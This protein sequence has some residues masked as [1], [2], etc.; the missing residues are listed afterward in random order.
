MQFVKPTSADPKLLDVPLE[1][2]VWVRGI[3]KAKQV[4]TK[5]RGPAGAP[6][7]PAAPSAGEKT[8]EPPV[9]LEVDVK[10]W[11]LLNAARDDLPFKPNGHAD[12]LVRVAVLRPSWASERAR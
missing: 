5:K 4:M 3:V 6:L 10:E 11:R 1:S 2:V 12:F 9:E 8:P 7:E